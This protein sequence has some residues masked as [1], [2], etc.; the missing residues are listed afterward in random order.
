MTA[1]MGLTDEQVAEYKEQG[2]VVLPS[3]FSREEIS[4]LE[5]TSEEVLKRLGPEVAREAD[6]SPHVC[7]GMH[8]F[9]ERFKAL[10]RHPELLCPVEQ[11]LGSKVFVHQSRINIKQKNGS[12]VEWHQDFGTYHRI[13]GIPEARGIM[14]GIFLDDVTSLSLIHI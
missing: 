3:V 9:D 2:W 5:R 8:L 14:V 12:I 13:D 1:V 4:V 10:T 6:G 7:W 11:L